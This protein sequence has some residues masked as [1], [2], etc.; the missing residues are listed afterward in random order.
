MCFL[1]YCLIKVVILKYSNSRA[2][3]TWC[4]HVFCFYYSFQE[5]Q[6][7]TITVCLFIFYEVSPFTIDAIFNI[8]FDGNFSDATCI[9]G[10]LTSREDLKLTID[11]NNHFADLWKEVRSHA[12]MIIKPL[13][14]YETSSPYYLEQ[15]RVL[16]YFYRL[17]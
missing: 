14:F 3:R 1:I 7:H 11:T 15:K 12:S 4:L 6:P 13:P 2:Y 8:L 10:F 16:H 9:F 5:N 17:F